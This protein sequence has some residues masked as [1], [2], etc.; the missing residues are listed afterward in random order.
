MTKKR[1]KLK[2]K[3]E[4]EKRKAANKKDPRRLTI[5][6]KKQKQKF[7]NAEERIKYKLEKAKVK[8]AL[9]IERLKR[10][11]VPKLQGPMVKPH[12]LTGEERFY[13]KKMAQKRSNYVPVGRR[14]IFGGVILNMHMHWKKHETVEVIC[15]PCKP[16]QVH[17]YA[18]EIARLSGGIPIQVIGDDT[19]IFYRGKNYVQPEIMSPIDTLSKKK[20]L[21][22][23]KYEQSLESVRRF[24][25]IAEKELELYHRHMAL[26]GDPNDRNPITILDGPSK[27]ARETQNKIPERKGHASTACNVFSAGISGTDGELSEFEDEDLL[28]IVESGSED[29]ILSD[30]DNGESQVSFSRTPEFINNL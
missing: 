5:K 14:G 24:I 2:R 29:D 21:E 6:G 15:K 7:A 12:E 19:I 20:A 28:S 17:E 10:Y 11:E 25:S 9:L 3:R 8:E 26:Y 27:V 16:G 30:Y 23:S 13:F 18:Q 22:K 1:L 4:K